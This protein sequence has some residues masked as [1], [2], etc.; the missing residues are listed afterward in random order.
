MVGDGFEGMIIFEV[1][2][3]S[4]ITVDVDILGLQGLS[5]IGHYFF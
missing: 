5:Y 2:N 3:G 1:K 4:N